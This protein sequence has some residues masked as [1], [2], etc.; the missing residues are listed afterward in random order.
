VKLFCAITSLLEHSF[1]LSLRCL[2]TYLSLASRTAAGCALALAWLALMYAA[3][4]RHEDWLALSAQTQKAALARGAHPLS[5]DYAQ[6]ARSPSP[7]AWIT[8]GDEVELALSDKGLE[9]T[10][11]TAGFLLRPRSWNRN[12]FAPH[13]VS[14]LTLAFENLLPTEATLSLQ[15]YADGAHWVAALSNDW[16]A[17]N[18]SELRFLR[19]PER[20]VEQRWPQFQRIEHQQLFVGLSES[21]PLPKRFTWQ[22]LDYSAALPSHTVTLDA[23]WPEARLR[24]ADELRYTGRSTPILSTHHAGGHWLS[25]LQSWIVLK[26]GGVLLLLSV[27]L[28][29]RKTNVWLA[30][31]AWIVPSVVLWWGDAHIFGATAS[32][33]EHFS[34]STSR[35]AVLSILIAASVWRVHGLST[36]AAGF[37]LLASARTWSL[38]VAAHVLAI[39]ALFF[40]SNRLPSVD[41]GLALTYLA[42]AAAQ[43]WLLQRILLRGF[44][45]TAPAAL[46]IALA[47][48]CFSALH[49]PNFTLMLLCSAAA[50]GWCSAYRAGIPFW[51]L[52]LSHACLGW[53]ATELLPG[54]VLRGADVAVQHFQNVPLR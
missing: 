39:G 5:I 2:S 16:K 38:F 42:F 45:A 10:A 27:L 11:D 20:S 1:V 12:P 31:A 48:L 36:Q 54:D 6:M 21:V 47:A 19:E 15:I 32:L 26:C 37:E 33:L 43:Q 13:Q 24:S 49:M 22:R 18:L 44:A 51:C 17:I 53:L 25:H 8:S 28:K 29:A 7:A 41:V 23:R 9:V 50:L 4:L 3:A 34:G 46:A 14:T 52:V 35:I 40:A 30:Q